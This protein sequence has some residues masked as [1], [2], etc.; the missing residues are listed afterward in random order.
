MRVV[1]LHNDEVDIDEVLVRRLLGAQ[2]PQWAALPLHLVD[3]AG[4]DNVMIRLGGTLVVRLPRTASAAAG[5][6]KEQRLVPRLAPLLPVAVP[7]PLGFGVPDAGYP[8]HWSVSPWLVGLPATPGVADG[9]LAVQLAEF[10][11]AL[12]TIDTFGLAAEGSLHSYRA[13]PLARRD[14]DTRDCI[15]QCRDLLDIRCV[16]A[17]WNQSVDV[18]DYTGQP[19]WMHADLQPGNL[20]IGEGRLSAVIDWGG[21]ALGDPAIDCLVA[22]T[23]LTPSTRPTF[24][25]RVGVDDATWARGRAWALSI[26][27][28]A[29][30]YYVHT[31]R[32]ITAWARHTI[33]QTVQ[34]IAAASRAVRRDGL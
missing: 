18:E 11:S 10:V 2:M 19:V 21:L 32:Q 33:T 34:D 30:P 26:A 28:V 1:K 24:R 14:E 23:L 9:R 17:A 12:R 22:W 15:Q 27:L 31:N 6:D 3:P 5:V 16:T 25:S 8:W 29:L 4:T 7:A 20:L 13:D